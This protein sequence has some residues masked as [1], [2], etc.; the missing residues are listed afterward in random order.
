ML[1]QPSLSHPRRLPG[2]A[3]G[4]PVLGRGCQVAGEARKVLIICAPGGERRDVHGGFAAVGKAGQNSS[5]HMGTGTFGP[6]FGGFGQCVL[7]HW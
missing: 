2:G 4:Q 1:L 3:L 6:S 5:R 7:A